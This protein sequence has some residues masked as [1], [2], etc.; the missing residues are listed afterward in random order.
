MLHGDQTPTTIP[1]SEIQ[2]SSL[3]SN[4]IATILS[5]QNNLDKVSASSWQ[6]FYLCVLFFRSSVK[7]TM[8][9]IQEKIDDLLKCSICLDILSKP[10][11]L[12]CL[13]TFCSDCIKKCGMKVCAVC[14]TKLPKK[15]NDLKA[16]SYMRKV[17][18]QKIE[19]LLP[20]SSNFLNFQHQ[21]TQTGQGISWENW[22]LKKCWGIDWEIWGI[23]EI[24]RGDQRA[25]ERVCW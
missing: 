8:S 24:Q 20:N 17:K 10:K 21:I 3:L 9:S 2:L 14:R 11:T 22:G 6:I 13:H 7:E 1:D 5:K 25:T 12:P 23:F 19:N 4:S 15:I 16:N 18:K